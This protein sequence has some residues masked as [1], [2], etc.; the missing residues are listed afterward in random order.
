[1]LGFSLPFLFYFDYDYDRPFLWDDGWTIRELERCVWERREAWRIYFVFPGIV[2]KNKIY[3]VTSPLR[4]FSLSVLWGL[5]WILY[6][7]RREE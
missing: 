3:L 2:L 6:F 7:L 5:V 4:V 1:L